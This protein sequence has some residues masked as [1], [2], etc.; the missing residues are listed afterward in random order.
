[1]F[2]NKKTPQPKITFPK[3]EDFYNGRATMTVQFEESEH[4][5][6]VEMTKSEF[7]GKTMDFEDTPD[8][9][10]GSWGANQWF[11]TEKGAWRKK[12]QSVGNLKQAITLSAKSRGLTVKS[13]LIAVE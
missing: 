12:Y 7:N 4:T 9:N 13:F 2:G 3:I 8:C 10:I 5:F 6:S 11:R 1:M